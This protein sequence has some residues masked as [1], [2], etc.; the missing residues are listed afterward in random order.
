MPKDLTP[1]QIVEARA[2]GR[3]VCAAAPAATAACLSPR[4]QRPPAGA[5]CPLPSW[6][7]VPTQHQHES[8]GAGGVPGERG[9]EYPGGGGHSAPSC[10]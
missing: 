9:G 7:G 3:G 1:Q 6:A 5:V 2:W 10:H 4:C 8:N